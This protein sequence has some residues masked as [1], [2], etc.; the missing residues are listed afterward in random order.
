MLFNSIVFFVFLLIVLPIFYRL[1]KNEHKK[2]WLLVASYIFY[3]YWDWRFCSLLLFS[4]LVDY[5]VGLKLHTEQDQKKRRSWLQVSLFVNLAL[6]ATFKYFN[7]FVDSFQSVL[8]GFGFSSDF[9]HL[10]ILLPV[11][12]SFYTFQTLSYTIDIYR[13]R[14]EPT[15]DFLSFALF[16]SFFPQLVAGPIERA[17]TLLPQ[18]EKLNAPSPKM[19]QDGISLIVLGLFKKVMIGDTAGRY[20]DHIFNDLSIYPSIEIVVALLLFTIQIYADFSGYSHIARGVAKLLGIE[21]MKNF[22]QP[23]FS[24]NITEFWHR[25]HISLSTWL[26]DYLYISIGGNRKGYRRTYINLFITMLLGGLWHGASWNFVIWGGLHG[27]YLML[28][29]IRLKG[30]KVKEENY[31]FSWSTL[32]KTIYSIASTFVLV[33]FTWLFFR[34]TT[35]HDTALFFSKLQFWEPSE[36]TFQYLKIALSFLSVTFLFDFFEYKTGKH[37]F[38]NVI[39]N[40]AVR[41]GIL[42]ALFSVSLIYIL[43]AKSAPF[44]YFQ[45]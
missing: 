26:R 36:F 5:W 33:S 43:Q 29:R 19:I 14:I 10:N 45:F 20:A 6:L 24:R 30:K 35:F 3:G 1:K 13:N 23:Y 41:Y 21:L 4:S 15:R 37:A 34:A 32:P 2:I 9:L 11:G 12:I 27:I 16:V 44:L 40:K 31:T 17:K 25:W 8:D 28:H 18:L 38:V 42:T 39:E 7:F 22:N